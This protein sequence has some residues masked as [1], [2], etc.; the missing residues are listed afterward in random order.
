M[1]LGSFEYFE[2]K[3]IWFLLSADKLNL[4]VLRFELQ[5]YNALLYPNIL[6]TFYIYI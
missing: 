3:Y 6:L 4:F 2:L 1:G 5:F